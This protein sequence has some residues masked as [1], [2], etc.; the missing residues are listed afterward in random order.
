MND[1]DKN[2]YILT[3]IIKEALNTSKLQK[4]VQDKIYK[5]IMSKWLRKGTNT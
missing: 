4:E 1:V 5:N 3:L 2:K